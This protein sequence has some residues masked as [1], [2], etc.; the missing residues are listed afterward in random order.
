[1]EQIAVVKESEIE[2]LKDSKVKT[3]IYFVS[4]YF[5]AAVLL[6]FRHCKN[7]RP[8]SINKYVKARYVYTGWFTYNNSNVIAGY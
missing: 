2:S 3:I 5:L 1:M 4:F 8:C 7:I 6:F